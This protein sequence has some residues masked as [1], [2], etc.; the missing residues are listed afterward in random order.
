MWAFLDQP[1]I[2]TR[3]FGAHGMRGVG[4]RLSWL[5]PIPWQSEF[6]AGAQTATG[7]RMISFLSNSSADDIDQRPY[8]SRDVNGLD[9]FIFALRWAQSWKFAEKNSTSLGMSFVTGPNAAGIN[10]YTQIYGV[11]YALSVAAQYWSLDFESEFLAR[12]YHVDELFVSPGDLGAL[13]GDFL[14]PSGT[15]R[16]YGFYSQ[17]LLRWKQKYSAGVRFE[18]ASGNDS[19]NSYREFDPTRD[20][21]FRFSPLVIYK[22]TDFT[23]FRLQYNF[24]RA[25]HLNT[26]VAHTFWLGMEFFYGGHSGHA[27]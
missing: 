19:G 12:N 14:A 9:D 4:L 22:P 21:R 16:D 24:D 26:G 20:N 23:R 5:M 1:V 10:T 3:I 27:P 11:D 2:N 17:L 25:D 6:F 8:Q 15:L 18:A 7:E 13:L